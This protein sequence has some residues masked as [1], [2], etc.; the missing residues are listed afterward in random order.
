MDIKQVEQ[1][2]SLMKEEGLTELAIETDDYKVSLKRQAEPAPPM[3]LSGPRD[4]A[5]VH[6]GLAAET[7]AEVVT[8]SAVGTFHLAE[9][10][11]I[12]A[13]VTAGQVVAVV[14]SMRIPHEVNARQGGVVSEILVPNGAAVEFDQPLVAI[15]PVGATSPGAE[16]ELLGEAGAGTGLGPIS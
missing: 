15:L 4:T 14:E 9:G 16:D 3:S 1:L 12:G 8:A 11:A 10:V 7:E 2:V 13:A 6:P 5:G